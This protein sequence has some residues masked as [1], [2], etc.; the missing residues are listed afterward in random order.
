MSKLICIKTIIS[1]SFSS[2]KIYY[3]K[4]HYYNISE[5]SYDKNTIFIINEQ[6]TALAFVHNKKIP[7]IGNW[8]EIK[9]YFITENE[10]RKNKL[11]KLNNV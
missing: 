6:G 10:L 8:G 7:N 4:N 1:N 3:K 5:N 9:D 2:I 11:K